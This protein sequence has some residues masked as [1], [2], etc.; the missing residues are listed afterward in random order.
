MLE[1]GDSRPRR[2]PRPRRPEPGCWLAGRGLPPIIQGGAGADFGHD[3][4]SHMRKAFTPPG[5]R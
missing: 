1:S 4:K 3:L 5:G 2:M